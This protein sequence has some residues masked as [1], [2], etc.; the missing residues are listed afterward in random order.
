LTASICLALV[1]FFEAGT[2]TEM[3]KIAT[4]WSVVNASKTI[5]RKPVPICKEVFGGRYVAINNL[6]DDGNNVKIPKGKKWNKSL[7]LAK[8]IVRKKIP[9]P[10]GGATHF[11]CTL[12]QGCK[13]PPWWAEGM[14]FKGKFGSQLFYK[15][16]VK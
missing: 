1:I 7:H 15:E 12:W 3:G 2:E 8:Q 5:H 14:E 4:G 16:I 9:D 11:E 10:T 6:A 13:S